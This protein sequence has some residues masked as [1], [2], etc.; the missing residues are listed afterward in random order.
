MHFL[1][2]YEIT[3]NELK[4]TYFQMFPSQLHFK[5]SVKTPTQHIQLFY[6]P[7][8]FIIIQLKNYNLYYFHSS[9]GNLT[10]LIIGVWCT[11]RRQKSLSMYILLHN[12]LENDILFLVVCVLFPAPPTILRNIVQG[13]PKQ[14]VIFQTAK[15]DFLGTNWEFLSIWLYEYL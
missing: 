11:V 3:V 8:H 1:S 12:S 2:F 13:E 5:F 14:K 15:N 6:L 7:N 10:G 9:F 4:L